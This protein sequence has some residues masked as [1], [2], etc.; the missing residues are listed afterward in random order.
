MKFDYYKASSINEALAL[1]RKYSERSA[2]L[3][4]GTDLMIKIRMKR[5]A[6]L[7][8]INIKDINELQGIQNTDEYIRIGPLVTLSEIAK[9]DLL[10]NEIPILPETALMMASPQVRNLGTIGGNLCNA[11]PSADM[12]PPL[13]ALDS[14]VILVSEK[15]E[16]KI[17]LED[18]FKGPGESVLKNDKILKSILIP[19]PADGFKM[20][21]RRHTLREA[22]DIAIIS[23]AVGF[24]QVDGNIQSSRIVLG[25]VAP[26]PMRAKK[27]E[28]LLDKYDGT[29]KIFETV[30]VAAMNES[31]PIND[32]RGTLEYRREMVKV[33]IKRTLGE[34]FN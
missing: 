12:A 5:F 2:F 17:K 30:A 33:L 10:K 34:L 27:A 22:M 3:A 32:V 26:I 11:A 4:G 31:L 29:N 16:E 7:T 15:G 8:L 23:A 19:K 6:P 24:L 13:I 1:K 21:Y 14:D 9:S 25:A 18:F 20:T 28:S